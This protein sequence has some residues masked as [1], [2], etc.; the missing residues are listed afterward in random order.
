MNIA[1]H[2]AL[3]RSLFDSTRDY[4]KNY[5]S[6]DEPEFTITVTKE[7]LAF[8]QAELLAEARAEFKIVAAEGYDC[9]I[10]KD[11]IPTVG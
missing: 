9:P 4:C 2:T 10:S 5:L 11:L 7:D 3:V 1:G 8:E 6:E